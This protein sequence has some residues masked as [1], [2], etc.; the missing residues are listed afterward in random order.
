MSGGLFVKKSWISCIATITII[1]VSVV[2]MITVFNN[3]KKNNLFENENTNEYKYGAIYSYHTQDAVV[4]IYSAGGE[5]ISSDL[6]EDVRACGIC[7]SSGKP[8]MKLGDLYYIVTDAAFDRTVSNC[9]LK[10]NADKLTYE[11]I[12][13]GMKK[14]FTY[15]FTI[16]DNEKN[17][18]AYYSGEPEWGCVYSTKINDGSNEL[19]RF[20]EFQN[21]GEYI[22]EGAHFWPLDMVCYEDVNYYIGYIVDSYNRTL[23][24]ASVKDFVFNVE[25]VLEGYLY[26]NGS[27]CIDEYL[28]FSAFID[29]K[30]SYIFRYNIKEK[31]IDSS[32]TL[33]YYSSNIDINEVDESIVILNKSYFSDVDALRKIVYSTKKLELEK[34]Y[35]IEPFVIMYDF[36]SE[37]IV[38]SDGTSIYVYDY[39]WKEIESFS[40]VS[41]SGMKFSGIFVK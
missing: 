10:L 30:A 28:Y 11:R 3:S 8:M 37:N 17:A 26:A 32:M 27:K 15:V 2:V 21:Y 35:E 29:S 41:V 40:L 31:S 38:C 4:Q 18:Y 14:N 16:D 1:I 34:I 20:D 33:E 39:N 5:L 7:S 25:T 6:I 12:D 36:C 23:C 24:V 13:M 22:S 19:Y 9:I